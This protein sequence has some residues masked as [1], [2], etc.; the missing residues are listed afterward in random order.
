MVMIGRSRHSI[1]ERDM[2]SYMLRSYQKRAARLR[3]RHDK[4]NAMARQVLS[5]RSRVTRRRLLLH[6][7]TTAS[8][9]TLAGTAYT[10]LV[11]PAWIDIA[12]VTLMLPRLASAFC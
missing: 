1:H 7:L 8:L 10:T 9:A 2:N 11:E 5:H 4:G 3:N 6:G 12:H